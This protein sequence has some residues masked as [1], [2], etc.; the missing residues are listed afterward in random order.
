MREEY[1][2]GIALISVLWITTLLA[3]IAASFTSSARTE[4]QLA[5]NLVENAK[6][7]ALADGAVHRAV[8]GILELEPERAWRTDGTAYRL[9]YGEGA[10]VVRI[11]DEDA[12]VDLNVAP[13]ELLT[14]VLRLVGLDDEQAET[15]AERIV[16]FRDED[17]EPEPNGAEDPEYEAAGRQGGALDRPLVAE[18]E[19]LGVLGMSEALYGRLRPFVTVYSGAEGIDPSRASPYVLRAVPGITPELVEAIRA[20]GPDGDP[21]ELI[22]DDTLF[23]IEVYFVPSRQIMYRVVAEART[24]GGGVFVRE[25]VI[26]LSGVPEQPFMVHS[27]GRGALPSGDPAG[28]YRG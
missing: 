8:L 20:A 10:V 6:A 5:R 17:D 22:D 19:L 25:A 3:V 9:N 24:T 18:A 27:W 23:E 15:L 28:G 12:K 11:F 2:R 13:L 4:N 7:E 26:E 21:F 14:G 16:D 1:Q